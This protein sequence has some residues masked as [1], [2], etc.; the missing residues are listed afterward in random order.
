MARD[1]KKKVDANSGGDGGADQLLSKEDGNSLYKV[2]AH[3]YVYKRDFNRAIDIYLILRDSAVFS[4]IERHSLFGVV[5]NRIIEL[6]E[7]NTDLTIRLL[8]DNENEMDS[9]RVVK[10]LSKHPKLQVF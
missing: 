9:Q 3:L 8:L 1:Y 2:L 6:M 4:V 7:I 10:L 5:Q